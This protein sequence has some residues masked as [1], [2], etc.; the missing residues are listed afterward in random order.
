MDS[1][2][3]TG[4]NKCIRSLLISPDHNKLAYLIEQEGEE[5]G[6]LHFKNLNDNSISHNEKLE[7]VFNFVWGSDSKIVYYTIPD[8][9]LRPY[10][11]FLTFYRKR[12][13]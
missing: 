9:Q 8:E 2:W 1:K 3:L 6:I 4:T 7:E 5:T 12:L 11:V 13:H 10:K